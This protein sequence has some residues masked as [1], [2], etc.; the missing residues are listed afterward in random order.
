MSEIDKIPI[1]ELISILKDREWHDLF[2]FHEKYRLSPVQVLDALNTLL[3]YQI[4]VREDCKIRLA[5]NLDNHQMAFINSI[6][7]TKKPTKLSQYER[8]FLPRWQHRL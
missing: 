2:E 7:K 6:Q 4:V 3:K 1:K 5:S 8:K